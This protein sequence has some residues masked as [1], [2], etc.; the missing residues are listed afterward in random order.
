MGASNYYS[1]VRNK[2][3][4]LIEMYG[5]EGAH[6]IYHL[7]R[8]YK[9][10]LYINEKDKLNA[11]LDVLCLAAYMHDLH[12]LQISEN[13]ELK[14]SGDIDEI[15]NE[16]C[17]ELKINE[18]LKENVRECIELT[19][20]HSFCNDV[21]PEEDMPIEGIILRDSDNL[22]SLGAVGIARAFMF[23]QYI[24]EDM[25]N[26]DE[27]LSD[28]EYNLIKKSSS[29]V[30]HFYEKLFKLEYDMITI[31]AK[32]IAKERLDYMEEY[33]NKFFEE[34]EVII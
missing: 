26:P 21:I 28:A 29:I 16:I 5:K 6:D 8:V 22:D 31:S 23:G 32:N 18:P 15:F 20:K 34:F 13:V 2:I 33:L 10:A 14:H 25:Y 4:K 7:D 19:D 3:K 27:K 1:S 30:H 24:G 17:E 11:N 9:M 12:R